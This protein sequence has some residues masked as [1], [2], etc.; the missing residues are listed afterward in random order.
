MSLVRQYLRCN[1]E[2]FG[3]RAYTE[4][5]LKQ[6]QK[7]KPT[8]SGGSNEWWGEVIKKTAIGAGAS[9]DGKVK[10]AAPY[11]TTLIRDFEM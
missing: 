4:I 7:E 6:V 10:L 3:L 1:I 2:K 11:E 5:A 8:Y 9:P